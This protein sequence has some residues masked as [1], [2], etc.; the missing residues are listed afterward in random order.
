MFFTC[1]S[2]YLSILK[3]I[4]GLGKG[5]YFRVVTAT[6]S[7]NILP[8]PSWCCVPT[9]NWNYGQCTTKGRC[10]PMLKYSRVVLPFPTTTIIQWNP[11]VVAPT[12]GRTVTFPHQ[13][14][15]YSCSSLPFQNAP[16]P[17]PISLVGDT[18][19]LVTHI[20]SII[21]T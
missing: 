16:F 14:C 2:T 15:R 10:P 17:P 7:K 19:G 13:F 4:I 20:F 5:R 3:D 11:L 12:K 1:I 9:P 18:Q 6:W 21:P 8:L